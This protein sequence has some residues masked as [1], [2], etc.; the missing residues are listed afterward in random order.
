MA[1]KRKVPFRRWQPSPARES[2]RESATKRENTT[3]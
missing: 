3:E 2:N 1:N